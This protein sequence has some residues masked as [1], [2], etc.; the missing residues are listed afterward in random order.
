M[1]EP[2]P[3]SEDLKPLW[4]VDQVAEYFGVQKS[5]VLRW[6]KDEQAQAGTGMKARKL[7]NRWRVTQAE[8]IRYRD[9][10]YAEGAVS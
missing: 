3:T 1:T 4:N 5:T 9:L 8:V 10:K 7:N 6:I 2:T